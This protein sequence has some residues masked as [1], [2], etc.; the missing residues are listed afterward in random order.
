MDNDFDKTLSQL[1]DDSWD[2]VSESFLTDDYGVKYVIDGKDPKLIELSQQ[3]YDD[4]E[5]QANPANMT[6]MRVKYIVLEKLD[7]NFKG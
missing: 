6:I 4:G 2:S 5:K 3:V 1:G 7:P